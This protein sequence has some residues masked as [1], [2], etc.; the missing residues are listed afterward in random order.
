MKSNRTD[1]RIQNTPY[2]NQN[3][4]V[5]VEID[6]VSPQPSLLQTKQTQFPQPL[7]ITRFLVP[8]PASLPAGQTVNLSFLFI[9]ELS[10]SLQGSIC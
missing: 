7:L 4:Q 2:F 3:C 10:E 8:S 1:F 6:E 9:I 5:V